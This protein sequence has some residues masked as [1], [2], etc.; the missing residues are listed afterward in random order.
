MS[1]LNARAVVVV[2]GVV[3]TSAAC[4]VEGVT[5][6]IPTGPSELAL[7]LEM[8]ATPD[9]ISQDGVSKSRLDIWARD[10]KGLPV[11]VSLRV[12]VLV[13]TANGPVVADYGTLSDRWPTTGSDGKASVVYQAPPQPAPTVTNDTTITLRVT[14]LGTNYGNSVPRVVE[15]RLVRPGTIRPPTRMVPRFTFSPSSPREHDDIFF[16]ASSSSDPDGQIASYFW[17][18]GDGSSGSGRQE[19]H[20]YDLAGTYGVVLTVTDAY[21]TSVSTTS[22]AVAITT[23]A[24]PVARFTISPTT[25]KV[26]TAV[27]FNA[28]AS[29]ASAGRRIVGYN[30]DLGN[31]RLAEGMAISNTYLTPGTY[32]VVLVVTDDAGRKGVVSQTLTVAAPDAPEFGPTIV[33][34][35]AAADAAHVPDSAW[36]A[37]R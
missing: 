22:T 35:A 6:P 18:F 31:G 5:V 14:P 15:V 21:G 13:P 33:T 34:V 7:S 37:I 25:P 1:A 12:D 4:S 24:S 16:D 30:W 10:P 8:S 29:T 32:T 26:G 2:L 20:S 11:R 36:E 17:Q 23:S 27:V 19:T 3:L 28:A 9:V